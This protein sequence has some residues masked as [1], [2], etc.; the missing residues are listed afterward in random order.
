ME[1]RPKLL[2]ALSSG[3]VLGFSDCFS[4]S[5]LV[6]YFMFSL[7]GLKM[8]LFA[9]NFQR[10]YGANLWLKGAGIPSFALLGSM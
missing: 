3:A 9:N 1:P 7:L 2:S 5:S 6:R 8:I 4:R 10:L